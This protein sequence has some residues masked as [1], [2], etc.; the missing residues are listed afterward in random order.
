M[1]FTQRFAVLSVVLVAYVVSGCAGYAGAVKDMRSAL[2]AGNKERALKKVN[3]ALDVGEPDELPDKV[4]GYDSLLLLERATIKQGLEQHKSSAVDFRASDKHL[5]LLDLKN[6]TMGNIG[7]F[8]FSDDSTVYKAPAYE[9][10]LLNTLNLLN[11]LAQYDLEGARVEARRMRVMQE[12]LADEESEQDAV[13]GLGS[14]L[15][16]FTFEMSGKAEQALQHYDEALSR[17]SYPSLSGPI[18]RLAGCTSYSTERLDSIIGPSVTPASPV[19]DES[20][21]GSAPKEQAVTTSPARTCHLKPPGKGTILVVSTVGLAPHKVARRIPIGAA[22][23]IAG[24]LLGAMQTAQAQRFA[25]K[26]LL[27]WINFPTMEKTP[28]RFSRTSTSIDGH[29][30]RTESG[31]NVAEQVIKAWDSIK[32]KL[33]VAAITRMI[34][35]LIAGTATEEAIKAAGG[36]GIGAL[37]AGLAVQGALTAADTPDTRS[38]TTLPSKIFIA[39]SEVPA[40]KHEIKVVFEGKLGR[41]VITKTVK[42]AEGGF[43]VVPMASMR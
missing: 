4:K 20:T 12:Y 42:V 2:L 31:L 34:T 26:G 18:R 14:Y 1:N 41:Y 25:A 24:A 10:L 40:G 17:E 7:K 38:W 22:I 11:Y 5:E 13:L 39:R 30:I 29:V 6:D 9:K 35:R 16:G 36:N 23:V 15:A 3:K 32:G 19:S 33:M 28:E 8:L 27:T 21:D 43:V 37:F